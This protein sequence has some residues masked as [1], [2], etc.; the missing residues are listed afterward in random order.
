MVVL[1]AFLQRNVRCR[2]G[3]GPRT[4]ARARGVI[5]VVLRGES[6]SQV[7]LEQ[8]RVDPAEPPNKRGKPPIWGNTTLAS[9]A[10]VHN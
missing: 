9:H 7:T 2:S 10:G 1:W 8:G 6:H 3:A 5:P 4:Q